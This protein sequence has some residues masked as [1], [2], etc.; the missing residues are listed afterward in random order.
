MTGLMAIEFFRQFAQLTSTQRSGSPRV[1]GS[2]KRSRSGGVRFSCGLQGG[3]GPL[4]HL[5]RRVIPR[6]IARRD[7]PV[8]RDTWDVPPKPIARLSLAA[9]S[10]L[11]RSSETALAFRTAFGFRQLQRHHSSIKHFLSELFQLFCDKS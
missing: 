7:T 3:V 4:A 9:T 2:T 5:G 8:W 11:M 10:R 1:T 6:I